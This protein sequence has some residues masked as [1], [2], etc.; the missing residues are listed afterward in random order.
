VTDDQEETVSPEPDDQLS[1]NQTD[2]NHYRGKQRDRL[3]GEW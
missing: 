3:N 1:T 2:A